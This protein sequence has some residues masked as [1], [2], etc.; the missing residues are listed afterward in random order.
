MLHIKDRSK[1]V[2]DEMTG[3]SGGPIKI[4]TEITELHI[5]LEDVIV[6]D[7]Q[8]VSPK[9]HNLPPIIINPHS[10]SSVPR[11][12]RAIKVTSISASQSQAN[13]LSQPEIPDNPEPQPQSSK[14][15][16]ESSPQ[17]SKQEPEPSPKSSKSEPE[18][19]QQ[20]N[21]PEPLATPPS[22]SKIRDCVFGSDSFSDS[23]ESGR[24]S[25]NYF[26]RIRI[27]E[28]SRYYYDEKWKKK[29]FCLKLIGCL[30]MA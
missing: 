2:H 17:L 12:K 10:S 8:Q 29:I 18:P 13:Q 19:S 16:P 26:I 28:E 5:P 25:V 3:I 15:G 7:I 30:P 4:K 11:V 27:R 21:R 22:S 24:A 14:P 1:D 20:L 6:N 9:S 23:S